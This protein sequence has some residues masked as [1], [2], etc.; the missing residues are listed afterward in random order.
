MLVPE[1]EIDLTLDFAEI[2][3]K[4]V[5]I[6]KQF[7]PFGP[8]NMSPIFRTDHVIDTGRSRIVGKN[9]LKLELMQTSTRSD[10]FSGIAFQ[11]GHLFDQIRTGKSFSICYHIEENEWMGKTSLQLN[12][13]DIKINQ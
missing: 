11:Q 5:R 2:T 12:V 8:G 3:A 1:I 13:K 9:H 6:L 4:F 10:A 7:A